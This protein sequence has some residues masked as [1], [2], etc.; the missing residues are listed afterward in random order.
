MVP[1]VNFTIDHGNVVNCVDILSPGLDVKTVAAP[2]LETTSPIQ[3]EEMT[4]LLAY[5]PVSEDV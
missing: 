2:S 3:E 1:I 4:E 5:Q